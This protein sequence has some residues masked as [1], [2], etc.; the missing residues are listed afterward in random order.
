M[1]N[2]VIRWST[3]NR[4]LVLGI[5]AVV[6]AWGGYVL[7]GLP[8]DVLPD[9]TAPTVTVIVE[10]PGM[11]PA[12]MEQLVTIPIETAMNGASGVRRVRSTTAIG[13]AVLWVEFDWGD[14]IYAARQTVTERLG[15]VAGLLPP[16]TSSPTLG[17]ISS[18]MGEILFVA[19]TSD[20]HGAVQ[21]RTF[22]DTVIRR[23]ILAIPGV[24]QVTPLGGARKQFEVLLSSERLQAFGVSLTE[25]GEALSRAGRNTSAGFRMHGGQEYL[26]RGISQFTGLEE[27]RNTVVRAENAIPVHIGQLA[28]VRVGEALKRGEGSRNGEPAV[29]IGIRKQPDGNTLD[30]TSRVVKELESIQDS[31]PVGMRIDT[32]V[33]RQSAFIETA[34]ANLREALTYGGLLVVVVVIAFLSNARASA[35]T[36]VAIPLSLCTTFF[37]LKLF[38]LTINSMTLGGMAIAIGELVDD[39]LVGVENAVRRLRLNR[40]L[41]REERRP[42]TRVVVD[43]TSEIRGSVTFATIIIVLVF[44]PVLALENVEGRLLRP[45]AIAYVTSLGASLVVALTVTPVL[46]SLLLPRT[47]AIRRRTEP[48][49]VRILKAGYR[50]TLDWSLNHPLLV[51]TLAVGLLAAAAGGFWRMGRSF[52][53]GFNE[54]SLT[55]TAISVPGTSLAESD[56]L[57]SALERILLEI[58]EVAGTGRR[59]GRADLDEHLQGVEFAEIDVQ[60]AMKDRTKEEVLAE[61]RARSTL[62]PGTSINVGQPISH[63]IDHMLSGTRSSIAVKIFGQDLRTLR[64]LAERVEGAIV[65]IPGVVDLAAEQQMNVPT[66]SVLFRRDDLARYAMPAG[67]AAQAL[68]TLFLGSRVGTIVE[69]QVP[70]PVVMR[71]AG[72]TPGDVEAIRRT[73][74]DT[75]SG[76]RAPLAAL[77]DVRADRTPNFVSRESVQRKIVVSCNVEGGDLGGVVAAIQ[78]RVRQEVDVPPGY[79]IEYGGQF[80]SEVRSTRRI[81]MAGSLVALGIIV[82][83]MTAFRSGAD[84][85]IVMCNLPLALVGGVA[86]VFLG[87]GIL[88]VASMIGFVTL[89]GIATRNGIMLVAHIKHLVAEEGETDLRRA[90]S[91]AASERLAPI[92]MTALSTGIALLPVALAAGQAGSEIH[93]PLALVVVCGLV[94]STALNMVVVPTLYFRFRKIGN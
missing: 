25:A 13:V 40:A 61:I 36:L 8:V 65:G 85:L 71:L 47:R 48:A 66:V 46:C 53:P 24:A 79:R 45:L 78:R 63:R 1:L 52:L 20:R 11:A 89:F 80:E 5:A 70:V 10:N 90:V 30:L 88:S 29:I 87:D 15:L 21:L 55:V 58:P 6:L 4:A 32:E 94:S 23:R 37:G 9:L 75:P 19:L 93:A 57:G 43:A 62:I 35:V 33:F 14:D 3:A 42:A 91:R 50:P 60:L 74:I 81:L 26:V 69:D 2:A 56:R 16:G 22:A 84:A 59:T 34:I 51:M 38:G 82:L 72:G 76:A 27:V 83:L 12:D 39:A 49:V 7:T 18:I 31:A 17:P 92:L 77:A 54:G 28:Q 68:R 73:M 44:V 67:A 86:G 41:P 64:T